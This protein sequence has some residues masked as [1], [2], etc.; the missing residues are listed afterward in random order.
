MPH[1]HPSTIAAIALGVATSLLLALHSSSSPASAANANA[2]AGHTTPP[3]SATITAPD[4]PTSATGTPVGVTFPAA[5]RGDAHACSLVTQR[6]ASA[7]LG[8]DPG[9]GEDTPVTDRA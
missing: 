4:D 7:A 5:A 9:S 1:P 8:T 6:E 2:P 3:S